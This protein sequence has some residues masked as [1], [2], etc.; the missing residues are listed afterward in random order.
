MKVSAHILKKTRFCPLIFKNIYFFLK[1]NLHVMTWP[2]KISLLTN[3]LLFFTARDEVYESSR[4]AYESLGFIVDKTKPRQTD[5]EHG[6]YNSSQISVF[7]KVLNKFQGNEV[8]QK[9]ATFKRSHFATLLF[10]HSE[11]KLLISPLFL[12]PSKVVYVQS[13]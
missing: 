12:S 3:T 5:T 7:V 13:F 4:F 9:C 10:L 1:P 11:N 2:Y 8:F 6:K